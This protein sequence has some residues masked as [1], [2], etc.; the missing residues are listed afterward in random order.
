[1]FSSVRGEGEADGPGP[2]REG[3]LPRQAVAPNG[4]DEGASGGRAEEVLLAA[5]VDEMSVYNYAY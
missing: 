2:R 3:E 4:P 1:M 5:V